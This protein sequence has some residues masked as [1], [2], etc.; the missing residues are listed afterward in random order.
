MKTGRLYQV[1]NKDRKE[2]GGV[3]ESEIHFVGYVEV[4]YLETIKKVEPIRLTE[5]E[6]D[7]LI[8][9][10]LKHKED[11]RPLDPLTK[12]WYKIKGFLL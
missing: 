11:F 12:L 9:N 10:G 4:E 8:L 1:R 5:K 3:K 7:K 6:F 2:Y